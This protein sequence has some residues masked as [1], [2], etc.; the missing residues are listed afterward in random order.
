MAK[1]RILDLSA[2]VTRQQVE[3]NQAADREQMQQVLQQ[4]QQKLQPPPGFV[5][6][7]PL[8]VGAVIPASLTPSERATLQQLSN[9]KEGDP[10]P[11]GLIDAIEA[12]RNES[13]IYVPPVPPDTPPLQ[14]PKEQ[15][16]T[17]L[18]PEHRRQVEQALQSV[19]AEINEK[20]RLESIMPNQAGEGIRDAIM[21]AEGHGPAVQIEDDRDTKKSPTP[22]TG[23]QLQ[24]EYCPHCNW[25][26]DQLDGVLVSDRDKETFMIALLG[27]KAFVK[28]ISL[29]DGRL[30]I[31]LR[32][33][34]PKESD[35]CYAAVDN[36]QKSMGR[37]F[38]P[39]EILE[40]VLRYK[41]A[42]QLVCLKTNAGDTTEQIFEFPES[43]DD[44]EM[45]RNGKPVPDAEKVPLVE[46]EVIKQIG[47]SD[48]L[49]RILGTQLGLFNRLVLKLE[50]N[51]DHPDFWKVEQSR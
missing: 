38:A 44:W 11:P 43:I 21:A 13:E 12:S 45:V 47:S 28:E 40:Y 46:A 4:A 42:L 30:K 26:L 16:I 32:T 27:L 7:P 3:E 34:T 29:F 14:M 22:R 19:K 5:G 6:T 25:K 20:A 9:W 8:P 15:D 50:G 24:L 48:A 10:L 2:G 18:S 33:L 36:M 31:T 51:V 23:A 37:I 35:A 41:M 17:Q 39:H 1:R 49:Y